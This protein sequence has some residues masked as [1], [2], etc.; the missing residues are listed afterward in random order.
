MT[1]PP[2]DKQLAERP[3]TI[4]TLH[5]LLTPLTNRRLLELAGDDRVLIS[6]SSE[7]E[8]CMLARAVLHGDHVAESVQYW[9][10]AWDGKDGDPCTTAQLVL[11]MRAAVGN[12]L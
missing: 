5:G 10:D 7:S 12:E 6:G 9:L 11:G 2:T 8:L 4:A 3:A 1:T